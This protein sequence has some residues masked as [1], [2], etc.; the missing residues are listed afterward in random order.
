MH[1]KVHGAARATCPACA[2]RASGVHMMLHG[3]HDTNDTMRFTHDT[4]DTRTMCV[5]VMP[6]LDARVFCACCTLRVA[7]DAN[8]RLSIVDVSDVLV[9]IC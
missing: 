3:T 8:A 9:C 2:S 7:G 4:H 5:W 6:A 1:T